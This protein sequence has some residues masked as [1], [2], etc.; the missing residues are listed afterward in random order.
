MNKALYIILFLTFFLHHEGK[1]QSFPFRCLVVNTNGDVDLF[2]SL[3][4]SNNVEKYRIYYSYN[5]TSFQIIDSINDQFITHYYHAGAQANTGS[6][7]YFLE[8]VIN[9]Q[10]NLI[11]DTLSTIFLQLDNSNPGRAN[12]YWNALHSPNPEGTSQWYKVMYEY[13]PGNWTILDSTQ[14]TQISRWI[15]VC[16]DSINFFIYLNNETCHSTSNITGGVFKDIEYPDKPVLDSVSV[17]ENGNVELGWQ[18]SDSSDVAGYIIYR[19]EGNIWQEID[20]VFGKENTFYT[21]T[22][23]DACLVSQEYSIASIDSCGNKSP[24]TFSLPQRPILLHPVGY[25]TCALEDSLRWEAYINA[26]P[27]LEKYQIFVSENGSGFTLAGEVPAS[28]LQYIHHD[29]NYGTT[30]QYFVRAVFGN[31]T[32]S[33]CIKEIFTA[34]YKRPKFA[35]LAGAGVLPN[36]TVELNLYVDTAV[37]QNGWQILR[38][39]DDGSNYNVIKD[40]AFDEFESFP[41]KIIDETVDASS[42][43][44]FYLIN[45]LDSCGNVAIQSNFNKTILLTGS[46]VSEQEVYLQW[47]AFEGWD[48]PVLRY[49]I[50][51]M[52]GE[53]TPAEA[54]DSVN[55]QTLSY[56][57]NISDLTIA[58]GRFT[59]WIEAVED[60][61]DTYGYRETVKSNRILLQQESKLYFPNAFAPKGT[62][63]TFKPVFNFFGG[64]EYLL[65][66]YNRWGQLIFETEDPAKG[67]DGTYKGNYVE[68]GVYIYKL[69]Y[70]N[71]FGGTVQKEGTVAVIF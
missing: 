52:Q 48:A 4:A 53:T 7:K 38:S 54:Y 45:A 12:L 57:D 42:Q 58:D 13:P 55:A 32:A 11:T 21:D 51:R 33:S 36:N 30:Y 59:Y 62:N 69:S 39:D 37:K 49:R 34:D 47:N 20:T 23:V 64:K 17:N 67:W 65:Q 8:A 43:S 35:Y 27:P 3:A 68:R 2:W 19:F 71:V 28:Q 61:G 24:G 40:V 16:E 14:N 26:S 25:S 18:P 5:G 63:N 50:Y 56:T 66:I 46:L 9:G 60:T 44:Y 41:F 6:R 1:S 15:D 22:T 29:L 10:N 70:K 31:K